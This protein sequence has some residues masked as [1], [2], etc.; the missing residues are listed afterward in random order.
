MMAQASRF[1][2][3]MA[4]TYARQPIADEEVY[5]I[6]LDTTRRYLRPEMSVFEFGCGTGGTALAH[7]PYVKHIE[8]IDFSEN[9]LAFARAAAN[10]RGIDNVTF[11]NAEI[12]GYE[13]PGASFDVVLGMSILHLLENKADVIAKVYRLLKPGGVFV[14]STACVGDTMKVFKLFAPLGQRLGLLPQLD[15]MTTAELVASLRAAGFAVEHQWQPARD[16]AVFIVARRPA[17][18]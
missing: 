11:S 10:D 6:K 7:A 3:K 4:D 8:A 15:V 18:R 16:Q 17:D 2:D 13:A 12:A 1:W 14:S 9:M 5:Q